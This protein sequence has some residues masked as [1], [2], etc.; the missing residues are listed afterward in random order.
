MAPEPAIRALVDAVGRD[1][2]F[3]AVA[4]IDWSRFAP[5]FTAARPRP[6]IAEIPEVRAALEKQP[7]PEDGGAG[8][9]RQRL[10]SASPDQQLDGLVELVCS[11]AAAVLGHDSQHP[12]EP[13]R[14]FREL[15]FDSLTAVE[16]SRHVAAATALSLPPSLVFDYPTPTQLAAS[17][18]ADMFGGA[19]GG[20]GDGVVAGFAE[21]ERLEDALKPGVTDDI[22][23]ERLTSRLRAL[24]DR[25]EPARE[26][27]ER[28]SSGLDSASDDELFDFIHR[29]LGR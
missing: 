27:V 3:V 22:G 15:G 7:T 24:L 23:R 17:L 19:R 12:V 28:S 21:L 13:N 6:L 25:L 9:L 20:D 8:T 11:T 18:H 16:L 5:S 1:E 29:E 14:S 2:E 26:P 4:D 10:A